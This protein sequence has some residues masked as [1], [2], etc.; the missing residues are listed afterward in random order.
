MPRSARGAPIIPD[1]AFD[2]VHE[3]LFGS[4]PLSIA[5]GADVPPKALVIK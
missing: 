1:R 3:A 4:T 5:G 2:D